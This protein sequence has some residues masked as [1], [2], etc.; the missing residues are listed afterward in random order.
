MCGINAIVSSDLSKSTNIINMNNAIIHRGPDSQGFI[1]KSNFSIGH[2]RLSIIDLSDSGKQPVV[3]LCNNFYMA[4]NGE[5]INYK[6]I[7]KKYL[8]DDYPKNDTSVVFE[9]LLKYGASW[10]L[11][12]FRGMFAIFFIDQRKN[13]F[14]MIRDVLGIKPLFY[15]L[16]DN[17]LI[18]SSEVKG[19]LSSDYIIPKINKEHLFYYFTERHVKAPDTL[20][21]NI[22]Q[23]IPGQI[24]TWNTK[25]FKSQ[26]NRDLQINKT[27]K[28]LKETLV[29]TVNNW[30]VSDVPVGTYL[31]GGLDSSL[32]SSII[33]TKNKSLQSW[34]AF[35]DEDGFS[36]LEFAEQVADEN[37]ISLNKVQ[38]LENDYLNK[39]KEL[40]SE[41]CYPLSV[42][43]EIALTEISKSMKGK[44][45]VAL[46]GEGADE[47][48]GGYDRIMSKT[49]G[50]SESFF[51]QYNYVPKNILNSLGISNVKSE[52]NTELFNKGGDNYQQKVFNYFRKYHLEGLLMRVDFTSMQ[53]S[54]ETRPCLVDLDLFSKAS[55]LKFSELYDEDKKG[56]K[57]L[58]EIASSYLN[59][60]IICRKKI[61]FPV[62]LNKYI[63]EITDEILNICSEET[64]IKKSDFQK[65]YPDIIKRPNH[66]QVL[67]MIFNVLYFESQF[68]N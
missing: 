6:E 31:S 9:C 67:W 50:S 14:T 35:F 30:T 28:S 32:I 64:V 68:I 45:K 1:N 3:S 16:I 61:G 23:V 19:I 38:V 65:T 34:C 57:P 4:Y 8:N 20:I 43:N 25:E 27:G 5:V 17:N 54:I 40:I 56:K 41:K 58:K 10:C 60:N 13:E 36:E 37:D 21:E 48:F 15:T 62:P 12:K 33:K 2:V 53:N 44:I 26:L 39:T 24:L 55:T 49:K 52:Y 66:G 47:L 7:S 51:S 63:N 46:S 29:S 18:V 22:Y 11:K 59:E 42:P